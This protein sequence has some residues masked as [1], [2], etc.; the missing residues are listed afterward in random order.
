V[1]RGRCSR[2]SSC[3]YSHNL[4]LLNAGALNGLHPPALD[5]LGGLLSP[6]GVGGLP[7]PLLGQPA[8]AAVAAAAA[9][10]AAVGGMEGPYGMHGP[11]G[12]GAGRL[13]LGAPGLGPA[14]CLGF[15]HPCAAA[16]GAG[17]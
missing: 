17:R 4:S 8:A 2:G 13:G 14:G 15:P 3:K 7:G 10:A 9:A 5:A 16:A 6:L 11:M 1:S 12:P